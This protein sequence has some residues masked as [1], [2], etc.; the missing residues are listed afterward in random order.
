MAYLYARFHKSVIYEKCVAYIILSGISCIF[1]ACFDS[2]KKK[3]EIKKKIENKLKS[4]VLFC[5]VQAT[6]LRES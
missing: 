4:F 2:P 6:V 1:L 3:K 5:F